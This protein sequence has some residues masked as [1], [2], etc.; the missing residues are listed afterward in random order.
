MAESISPY[1]CPVCGTMVFAEAS[2]SG[3]AVVLDNCEPLQC[4]EQHEFRLASMSVIPVV[5]I[6][7][8]WLAVF[9]EG[10]CDESLR[11]N[12]CGALWSGVRC[13]VW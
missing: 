4:A 13:L 7:F 6:G 9:L 8:A 10:T 2:H 1:I 12:E 11:Q 5:V 3:H